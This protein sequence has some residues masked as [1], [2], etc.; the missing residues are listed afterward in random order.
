MSK[1]LVFIII[2]T[3][4]ISKRG[5]NFGHYR[6]G[7]FK[8]CM[9][10]LASFL[11]MVIQYIILRDSISQYNYLSY[12][13]LASYTILIISNMIVFDY[14]DSIYLHIMKNTTLNDF[15][16]LSNIGKSVQSAILGIGK[17]HILG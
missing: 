16:L 9:F 3:V 11:A 14:I 8:A 1:L 12:L 6:S 13:I 5:K 2:A 15:Y 10:P 4:R 7:G 17:K